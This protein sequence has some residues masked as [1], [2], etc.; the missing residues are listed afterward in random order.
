MRPIDP[1]VRV[2]LTQNPLAKSRKTA[3]HSSLRGQSNAFVIRFLRSPSEIDKKSHA[4]MTLHLNYLWSKTNS[5]FLP[6]EPINA[7]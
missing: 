1:L 2:H 6:L 5:H 4:L 7:A 3:R